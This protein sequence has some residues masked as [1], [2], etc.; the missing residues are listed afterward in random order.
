MNKTKTL[1]LWILTFM[2][3]LTANITTVY[4][5]TNDSEELKKTINDKYKQF[6]QFITENKPAELATTLY[7]EDAKFYPPNGIFVQGRKGVTKAFKG[8]IGAGL[9]IKPEAQ[10]VEI[11]GNHAYEYG[12]GTVYNEDGKEIRKERYVCIWK[13]VDDDWKI[14][15]DIVQGIE[16]K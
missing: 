12:I 11:F 2:I 14:Y 1:Q 8:M 3:L 16:M 5:Q 9:V 13:K 6:T 7:T 10:E 15:R 4:A